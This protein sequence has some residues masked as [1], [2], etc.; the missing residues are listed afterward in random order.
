MNELVSIITPSYNCA[1]FIGETIESIQRQTY[2]NWELLITDDCSTD[3]SRDV[4]AAYA[5]EDSRI[6][7]YK[8]E[9][10]SGAGSARNNSIREARGRFIAFCDSDDRWYP[11]KLEQQ[12]KFMEEK[13]C[14][15]SYTS[16]D[17]CDEQGKIIGYV[18]CLDEISYPKILRDN[19]V[20]CL[21]AMYDTKKIGK[22]YMPPIRKRQDWCLWIEIIRQHGV[23]YGLRSPLALYRLRRG[24]ISS[25]KIEMLRHN[26][27]V[28]HN[29]VGFNKLTSM[30][31]LLGYF[32]PYYFYK[33]IKQK[34]D[35]K[36]RKQ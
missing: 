11:A 10:N 23:A 27:N 22:H 33:K 19:G 28:Y 1:D 29:V 4:I 13:D 18:E 25:N 20:G 32:M 7:L 2:G 16:Y 26:Y 5:K 36:K 24:S 21:T 8:L 15:L 3:N 14:G 9:K 31:M 30:V 6:K 12:V 34:I 35:Y 17:T